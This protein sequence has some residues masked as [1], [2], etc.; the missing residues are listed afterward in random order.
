MIELAETGADRE[1]DFDLESEME[2]R[3][4]QYCK[5]SDIKVRILD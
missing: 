5:D 3:Y 4:M 1:L 2:E